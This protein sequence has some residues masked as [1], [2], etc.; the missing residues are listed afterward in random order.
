MIKL[1]RLV[2]I[3]ILV[4]VVGRMVFLHF[5]NDRGFPATDG[6]L[7]FGKIDDRLY[8]GAQPDAAA[9]ARLKQLGVTTIINL[10][11]T[12]E[13]W[14]AE[15]AAALSNSIVYTNIPLEGMGRP[16]QADM[17]RILSI[18]NGA[19]GPVF[20]HCEHGCDRTGTVIACYRIQHDGW[21]AE[22]ALKEAN[23]YGMSILERGM[24]EYVSD[25][26][27]DTSKNASFPAK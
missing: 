4:C 3:V 8:R 27:R 19:P 22:A 14:S 11:T 23:R 5:A 10:R 17:A 21:D 2:L 12:K 15:A 16:A 9:I 7:N 26:G 18:I 25:F 1:L 20:V 24:R 13:L 6:I